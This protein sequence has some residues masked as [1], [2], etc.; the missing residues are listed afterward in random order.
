MTVA[1]MTTT[2]MTT[3]ELLAELNERVK[4]LYRLNRELAAQVQV[5]YVN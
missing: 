3:D 2:A 5:Y 4:A 1:T